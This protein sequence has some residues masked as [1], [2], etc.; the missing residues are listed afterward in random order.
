MDLG[1]I[2]RVVL[3]AVVALLALGYFYARSMDK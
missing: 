3:V 2:A 1:T